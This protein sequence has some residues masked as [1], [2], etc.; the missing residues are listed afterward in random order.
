ML[1]PERDYGSLGLSYAWPGGTLSGFVTANRY[2]GGDDS[3]GGSASFNL[4]RT[5]L[6]GL[7][8]SGAGSYWKRNGG[9]VIYMTPGLSYY[10]GRIRSQI[11]YNYYGTN[12]IRNSF[13]THTLDLSFTFP[14]ANRFYTTIRG[15]V[16]RG[17]NL[18]GNSLFVSL[19]KSF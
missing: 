14:L 10:F 8:F 5:S 17:E 19:W 9:D 15:R 7:G 2:D 16:Q 12:T 4:P 3:F 18:D 11:L 13:V 6:A 1:S